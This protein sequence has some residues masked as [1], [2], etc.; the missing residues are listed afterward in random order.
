M[1]S[2]SKT[3]VDSKLFM[4]PYIIVAFRGC[5]SMGEEVKEKSRVNPDQD[6]IETGKN[7]ERKSKVDFVNECSKDHRCIS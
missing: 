6:V 4:V 2:F 7:E 3:Q 1:S 5:E